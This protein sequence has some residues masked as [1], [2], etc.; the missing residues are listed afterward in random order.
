VKNGRRIEWPLERS[1]SDL[2]A[3]YLR[4]FRPLV[5]HPSSDW[6]LPSR[7]HADRPRDKSTLGTAITDV[8][9]EHVGV[10]M[11]PHLFRAFAGALILE[12]NPHAIDELRDVLGHWGFETA[13]KH[14]RLVSAK[15]AAQRLAGLI[16]RKR[17]LAPP[18][19]AK[20]SRRLVIPTCRRRRS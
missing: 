13:L 9:H 20:A 6:L 15:G 18:K 11:N 12:E 3:T 19:A 4:D 2:I 16:S 14:Y 10:R 8:I 7:D 1:T 17:N 5:A